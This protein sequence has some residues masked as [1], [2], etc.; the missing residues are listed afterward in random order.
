MPILA[1]SVDGH[2]CGYTCLGLGAGKRSQ[3]AAEQAVP[4][5]AKF[6]LRFRTA[7]LTADLPCNVDHGIIG[8]MD[9]AHGPL[10]APG[11]VVAFAGEH[12]GENEEIRSPFRKDS[13]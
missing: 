8:L 11:L 13:G 1:K 12:P 7:F 2:A 6:G 5:L 3:G 4:E 10:R 9:P